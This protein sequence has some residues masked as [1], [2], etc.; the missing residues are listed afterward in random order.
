MACDHRLRWY[1]AV[2]ALV[3]LGLLLLA[4]GVG[5][6]YDDARMVSL[7]VGP[8]I[9]LGR[10]FVELRDGFYRP[11][12]EVAI[13]VEGNLF[14]VDPVPYHLV[15]VALHLACSWLVYRI[16]RV[17]SGPAPARRSSGSAVSRACCPRSAV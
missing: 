8:A 9:H 2:F 11:I 5:F 4:S 6:L 15:N 16:A 17:D 13:G 10:S 7:N 1:V 3:P 14:G 12:F